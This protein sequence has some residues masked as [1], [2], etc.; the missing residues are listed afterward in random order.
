MLEWSAPRHRTTAI[1]D[2]SA[3]GDDTVWGA[4]MVIGVTWD[5]TPRIFLGGQALYRGTEDVK[6][7]KLAG[8]VPVRFNGDLDGYAL[9]FS[10]GFRF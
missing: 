5:L 3:D 2:F 6:I 7:D 1:G 4:H 9:T 10:G 8:T